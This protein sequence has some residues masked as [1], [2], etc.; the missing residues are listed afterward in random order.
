MRWLMGCVRLVR[1]GWS[2]PRLVRN[3]CRM[4][5]LDRS[6]FGTQIGSVEGAY[7][8]VFPRPRFTGAH[9]GQQV[10][11]HCRVSTADQSC[12]RQER[13]LRAYAKRAGQQ[14]VGVF[15]E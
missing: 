4:S 5:L 8:L 11:S 1:A 6:L 2:G 15:K 7:F 13:D 14:V 3:A 12:E 9:L 10:A